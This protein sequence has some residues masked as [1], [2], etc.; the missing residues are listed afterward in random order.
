MLL[1]TDINVV[2]LTRVISCTSELPE[3]FLV[4]RIGI[5]RTVV[6]ASMKLVTV[7][8]AAIQVGTIWMAINHNYDP[9]QIVLGM[10]E[11]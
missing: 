10:F 4:H 8:N 6:L 3:R 7:L 2:S 11:S 5:I 1:T 9:L